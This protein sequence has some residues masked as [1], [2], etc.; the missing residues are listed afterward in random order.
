MTK[1][2]ANYRISGTSRRC[3]TCSMFRRSSRT[4]TL[5]LGTIYAEDVCDY[6]EAKRKAKKRG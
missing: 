1:V 6:W 3:E 4:C 2:Q 5:V